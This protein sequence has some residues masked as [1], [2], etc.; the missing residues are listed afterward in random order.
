TGRDRSRN[1]NDLAVAGNNPYRRHDAVGDTALEA[2]RISYHNDRFALLRHRLNDPQ[3][4]S[5]R[6]WRVNLEQCQITLAIDGQNASNAELAAIKEMHFDSSRTLNNVTI[7]DYPIG[8]DEK[9]AA[10]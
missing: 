4:G 5:T 10:A 3:W 9:T 1:L 6:F 2:V 8:A 7:R